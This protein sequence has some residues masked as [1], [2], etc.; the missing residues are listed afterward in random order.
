M[1]PLSLS[2]GIAGILPLI[3]KAIF[4][5]KSYMDS[6]RTR[7]ESI[8][9]LITEL[10][11]LQ[12]NIAN[13]EAFLKSETLTNTHVIFSENSV[14]MSC[15]T[16]CEAKL[17]SLC[18]RLGQEA[19]GKRSRFLWPFSEKEHRKAVQELRNF[20]T[21]IRFA[22]SVDGC[23][24]LSRASDDMLKIMSTQLDQFNLTK[25]THETTSQICNAV[26]HQ[27]KIIQDSSD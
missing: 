21:W 10:E 11:A 4:G 13:L 19:N 12:S 22:L 23:R 7:K 9:T 25:S 1:D 18:N 27:K 8:I 20:T 3:T 15:R 6:V 5:A 24:L 26:Q 17:Q 14:L 16:A 2:F